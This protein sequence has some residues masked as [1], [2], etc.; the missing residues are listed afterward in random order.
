EML[1]W[2]EKYFTPEGAIKEAPEVEEKPA[3]GEERTLETKYKLACTQWEDN[4]QDC[5]N[6]G[7]EL[8]SKY[9]SP[10]FYSTINSAYICKLG[11]SYYQED[12]YKEAY[13]TFI[14]LIGK[15]GEKYLCDR[16]PL[17]ARRDFA[18]GMMAS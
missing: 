4:L 11:L 18:L 3:E 7:E 17:T 9:G 1:K 5:I 15:E 16:V 2:L 10:K 6:Y 8:K 14:I 12:R 13:E